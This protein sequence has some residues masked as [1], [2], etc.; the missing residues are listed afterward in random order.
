MQKSQIPTKKPTLV[1]PPTTLA[2]VEDLVTKKLLWKLGP[3]G[4][5]ACRRIVKDALRELPDKYPYVHQM[6]AYQV[7]NG[8]LEKLLEKLGE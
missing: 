1:M 5:G 8:R 2:Q 6:R 4:M 3:S 7:E